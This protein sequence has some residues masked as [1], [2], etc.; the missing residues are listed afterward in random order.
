MSVP[1]ANM[2]AAP[3]WCEPHCPSPSS[4]E[5]IIGLVEQQTLELIWSLLIAQDGVLRHGAAKRLSNESGE[6]VDGLQIAEGMGACGRLR[7]TVTDNGLEIASAFHDQIFGVFARLHGIESY[8]GTGIALPIVRRAESMNVEFGVESVL[9]EG[10]TF[11]I[12]F[13][14][15]GRVN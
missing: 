7:L 1:S 14:D 15:S 2:N 12:E 3:P 6:A 5:D 4:L 10:S 11:W 8:P 13:R 9:G